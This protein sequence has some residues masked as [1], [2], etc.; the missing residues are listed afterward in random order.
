METKDYRIRKAL[1][2]P[3]FICFLLAIGLLVISWRQGEPPERL[4]IPVIFALIFTLLLI[5]ALF[6][7]LRVDSQGVSH[8]RP[9][10]VKS[11]SFEEIRRFDATRLR[12]RVFFAL[13]AAESHI[14]F[15]NAYADLE[16]LIR[17]LIER[18]PAEAIGEDIPPLTENPPLHQG[19]VFTLW[20]MAGIL[21]VGIF[22]QIGPQLP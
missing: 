18:L 12:K 20:L 2:I 21:A 8:H 14:L 10:G 19:S 16:D 9:Y 1:L 5:N 6:R 3:Q 7:R 15:S 17:T 11:L 4:F 13:S 22:L